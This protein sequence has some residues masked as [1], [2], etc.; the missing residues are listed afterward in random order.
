M[1]DALD[2]S[3]T[4]ARFH[5]PFINHEA[6]EPRWLSSLARYTI[7]SISSIELEVP[8]SNPATATDK[9]DDRLSARC[10]LALS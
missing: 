8:S 4:T 6:T 2:R 7:S 1:I 5:D 9:N 3:A 10:M